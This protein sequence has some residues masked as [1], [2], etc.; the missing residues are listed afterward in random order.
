MHGDHIALAAASDLTYLTVEKPTREKK[1]REALQESTW[2]HGEDFLFS[3]N[4][5]GSKQ[6]TLLADRIG[7]ER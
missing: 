6:Q 7:R 1:C 4:T 5:H 3:A 2:M